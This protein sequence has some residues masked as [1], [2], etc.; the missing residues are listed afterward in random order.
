MNLTGFPRSEVGWFTP[1]ASKF[2]LLIP[3]ASMHKQTSAGHGYLPFIAKI[4][5]IKLGLIKFIQT[6]YR[7]AGKNLLGRE[8]NPAA[9]HLEAKT[10]QNEVGEHR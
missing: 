6:H 5:R 8:K 3:L 9:S 4:Y 7:E 10:K 1:V 2:T